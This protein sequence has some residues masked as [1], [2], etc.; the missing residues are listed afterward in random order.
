MIV[1]MICVTL[2]AIYLALLIYVLI[3]A[4]LESNDVDA[5]I[6]YQT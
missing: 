3:I 6:K 1:K 2:T 4:N 5:R